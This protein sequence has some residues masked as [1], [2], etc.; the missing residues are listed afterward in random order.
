M[1]RNDHELYLPGCFLSNDLSSFPRADPVAATL[2]RLLTMEGAS[3]GGGLQGDGGATAP[4]RVATAP[5]AAA[6]QVVV[7]KVVAAPVAIAPVAP[8]APAEPVATA[9]V[10]VAA[11][12]ATA[13]VAAATQVAAAEVAAAQVV[14]AAPVVATPVAEAAASA[15]VVAASVTSAGDS[16]EVAASGLHGPGEGHGRRGKQRLETCLVPPRVSRPRR[17]SWT[18]PTVACRWRRPH[19]MGVRT[20]TWQQRLCTTARSWT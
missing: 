18:L 6:T 11:P 12:V 17:R 9:P 16:D 3:L 8:V 14:V 2:A 19:P 13:P 4:V 7:A 5:V 10:G 1:C 20:C 15:P